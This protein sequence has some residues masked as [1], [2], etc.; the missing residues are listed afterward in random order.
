MMSSRVNNVNCRFVSLF[1]NKAY[2]ELSIRALNNITKRGVCGK[3][4]TGNGMNILNNPEISTDLIKSNSL[5][6][7]SFLGCGL[8][9]NSNFNGVILLNDYLLL[10]DGNLLIMYIRAALHVGQVNITAWRSL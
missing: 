10:A 3:V 7:D 8:N 9:L 6:S 4:A 2:V 5:I 1:S